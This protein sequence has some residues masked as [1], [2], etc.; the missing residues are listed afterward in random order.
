ME[1]P[2]KL[3]DALMQAYVDSIRS[4]GCESSYCAS[5]VP[6]GDPRSLGILPKPVYCPNPVESDSPR[7]VYV[8][9]VCVA[10]AQSVVAHD[11]S[12]YVTAPY[13]TWDGE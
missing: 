12:A 7:M 9:K 10:C 5:H 1:T 11:G 3:G 13:G 4:C 2:E 8:G 6:Y